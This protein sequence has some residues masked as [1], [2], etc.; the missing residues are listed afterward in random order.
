MIWFK[1][2]CEVKPRLRMAL[3][4]VVLTGLS[5]VLALHYARAGLARP[6]RWDSILGASLPPV[7][8]SPDPQ[9]LIVWRAYL[10]LTVM[11]LPFLGVMMAGSG[12]YSR[13][14]YAL[15]EET[16]PS[17]IYTLALPVPRQPLVGRARGVGAQ[18]ADRGPDPHCASDSARCH[19]VP[20]SAIF[21]GVAAADGALPAVGDDGLLYARGNAGGDGNENWRVGSRWPRFFC[22]WQRNWRFGSRLRVF[23]FLVE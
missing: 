15:K 5:N 10:Q 9:A 13:I 14:C 6:E 23:P 22:W 17:M 8:A 11:L 18:S 4:M 21:L 7:A 1:A 19:D 3:F 2:W 12:I 16:H 20:A